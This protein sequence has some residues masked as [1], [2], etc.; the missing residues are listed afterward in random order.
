MLNFFDTFF[1]QDHF[2]GP[3]AAPATHVAQQPFFNVQPIGAV[4]NPPPPLS[5]PCG[6]AVS[7]DLLAVGFYTS[8]ASVREGM[9]L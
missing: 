5:V 7:Q 6:V 2:G 9:V 1:K 3:Q 4:S 8:S